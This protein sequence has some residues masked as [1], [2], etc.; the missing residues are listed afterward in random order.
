[1][2]DINTLFFVQSSL[3]KDNHHLAII[4]HYFGKND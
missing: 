4:S 2:F 1:M 3:Y